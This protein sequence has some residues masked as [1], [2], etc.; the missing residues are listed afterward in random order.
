[1][2]IFLD[3]YVVQAKLTLVTSQWKFNVE[4]PREITLQFQYVH[5]HVYFK[6]FKNISENF[7]VLDS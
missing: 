6:H 1:M 5:A 2:Q 7:E 4:I 3:W